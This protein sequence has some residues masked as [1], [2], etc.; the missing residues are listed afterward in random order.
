MK[1]TVVVGARG[2]AGEEQRCMHGFMGKHEGS[3][4]L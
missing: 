1:E 3:R 4:Q 2:K